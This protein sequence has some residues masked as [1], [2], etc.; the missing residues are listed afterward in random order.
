MATPRRAHSSCPVGNVNPAEGRQLQC[1]F[2]IHRTENHEE[3]RCIDSRSGVRC[4]HPRNS[5][6]RRR[7]SSRGLLQIDGY[8]KSDWFGL[9]RCRRAHDDT[10]SIYR[11]RPLSEGR[12]APSR[13]DLIGRE[14]TFPEVGMA[15]R[16]PLSGLD[17]TTG[18]RGPFTKGSA[19]G[20]KRATGPPRA[21]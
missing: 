2:P 11:A 13:T 19:D 3:I 14:T 17:V 16:G 10:D 5:G 21:M 20:L 4:R 9:A 18:C 8:A 15:V 6:R 12:S 1:S 7:P